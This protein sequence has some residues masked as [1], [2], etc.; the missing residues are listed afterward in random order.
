MG[1]KPQNIWDPVYSYHVNPGKELH[2]GHQ[3]RGDPRR[4]GATVPERSQT[5]RNGCQRRTDPT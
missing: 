3:D 4:T 2:T 5:G 1:T